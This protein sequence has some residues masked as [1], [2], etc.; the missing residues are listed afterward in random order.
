MTLVT[1]CQDVYVTSIDVF[2]SQWRRA[3][4]RIILPCTCIHMSNISRGGGGSLYFGRDGF[5]Y[6]KKGAIG[7]RRSTQYIPGGGA[8]TN[9]KTELFNKYKPGETGIGAQSTAVRRA[10]NIR[11]SV[12]TPDNKCSPFYN[13]LGVNQYNRIGAT[14][15]YPAIYPIYPREQ[16]PYGRPMTPYFVQPSS[17]GG[18]Q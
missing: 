2:R 11:A 9:Q 13:T 12:C 7:G 8:L 16:N 18:T 15:R 5:L 6:K 3:I 1:I 4:E 10:K 17:E 14:P